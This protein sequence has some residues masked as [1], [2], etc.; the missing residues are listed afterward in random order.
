MLDETI[1][2]LNTIHGQIDTLI[3]K[4][5]SQNQLDLISYFLKIVKNAKIIKSLCESLEHG[6]H[7]SDCVSL[8]ATMSYPILF[9]WWDWGVVWEWLALW[10]REGYV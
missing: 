3:E 8:S 6:L 2:Y 7:G 1:N 5:D 10:L 9:Y 4:S